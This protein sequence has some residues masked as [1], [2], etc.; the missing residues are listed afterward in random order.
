MNE[1]TI[2]Y[3]PDEIWKPYYKD[4]WD[5]AIL[6]G[7]R[8]SGKTWNTGNRIAIRTH[9][10]PNKRTL[11]LRDVATSI[12]QSIL[13][14]IKDRFSVINEKSG[15][16]Y[17]R[18]FEVQESQIKNIVENKVILFTKGFRQSRVGQS[19]DLKGFEDLDEAIIEE[20]EDLRD[21]ERVNT[22]LDTMRKDG[23]KVTIILNTPDLDHWIVRRYF[24]WEST[25]Y[26]GYYKLKP[27]K[28][29]GVLQI[30]VN[31][32]DN[33]H[34]P[35][36]TRAKYDAY[37]DP[38]SHLYNPDYYASK[39]LGLAS[40]NQHQRYKFDLDQVSA[41]QTREPLKVIDGVKIFRMPEKAIYSMG[42]DASR[43]RQ[44]GDYTSIKLRQWD[45][46]GKYLDVASYKGRA[47]E[48]ETFNIAYN[49]ANFYMRTGKVY[50]TPE[51][52]NM[53][54]YIVNKFKESDYPEQ[55]Q[56]KRYIQDTTKQYDV[57]VPDYG[58]VT[59]TKT[60]P[61]MINQLADLYHAN[62]LEILDEDE[63]KEMQ[64]FVWSDNNRYEARE[65]EHDDLLFADMLVVQGFD[66]IAQYG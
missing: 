39:I 4:N 61:I 53:G 50:I 20:A 62:Q 65:G 59:S 31:Y 43:G 55:L 52:N 42:I 1:I 25:E 44:N 51:V 24:E 28:I 11:V 15:G 45:S 26:K 21:E 60:R 7:S 23:Y 30:I 19:A 46:K 5:L 48:Q 29:K 63:K 16:Q 13:Q 35:A 10:N 40:K 3:T 38:T 6:I 56:Y 36:K 32:K 41:I 54:I 34:L 33:K 12:E 9:E 8:A 49:L 64:S 66:Y 37:G 27:K 2:E 47:D 58:F 22:L 14:N 57:L 18:L 17:T